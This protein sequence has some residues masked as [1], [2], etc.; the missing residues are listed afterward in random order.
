MGSFLKVLWTVSPSAGL[1]REARLNKAFCLDEFFWFY[2]G[3]SLC[4]LSLRSAY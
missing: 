3:D 1:G 4:E 2:G